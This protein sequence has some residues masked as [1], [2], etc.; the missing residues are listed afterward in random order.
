MAAPII[1]RVE[2]GRLYFQFAN[3]LL[4]TFT[5]ALAAWSA[6]KARRSHISEPIRELIAQSPEVPAAMCLQGG[7]A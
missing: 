2:R 4:P 3:A 6:A 1:P 7:V 5:A